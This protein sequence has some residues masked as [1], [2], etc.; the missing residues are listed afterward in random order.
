[1]YA[2]QN[3]GGRRPDRIRRGVVEA[4]WMAVIAGLVLGGLLIAFG[5]PMVRLFIGEG[6]D[7][8]VDE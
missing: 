6:S 1:M 2:A 5:A 3:H 4:T 8:V 7:D